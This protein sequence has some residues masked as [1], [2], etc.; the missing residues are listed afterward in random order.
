MKKQ[1]LWYIS[2]GIVAFVGGFY[3]FWQMPQSSFASK[4]KTRDINTFLATLSPTPLPPQEVTIDVITP[5]GKA[6][7]QLTKKPQADKTIAYTITT[8]DGKK[9]NPLV[10]HTDVLPADCNILLPANSWSPDNKLFFVTLV[11]T[12]CQT[13]RVFQADGKEW[14]ENEKY[15]DIVPLF[16][17]LETDFTIT[18]ATGWAA[19]TL[20]IITTKNA[21]NTIGPKYWFDTSSHSFIRLWR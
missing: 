7:V 17:K 20:V 16:A 18:N 13:Y 5:D 15:F 10:V 8:L 21:D 12:S 2:L 6:Y 9:Q 19:N 1:K 4:P 3:Y 14:N 11:G